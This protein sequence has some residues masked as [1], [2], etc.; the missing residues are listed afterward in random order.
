MRRVRIRHA[1]APR[2]TDRSRPSSARRSFASLSF[3]F[4]RQ[5][6]LGDGPVPFD[7]GGG[8]VHGRGRFLDGGAAE[9]PELDEARLFGIEVRELGQC[10]VEIEQV[11]RWLAAGDESLVE[12][13]TVARAAALGG[14]ARAGALDQNLTH[15][16]RGDGAEVGA[17]LPPA[18]AVLHQ[19]QVGLV[20][21]RRRLQR[22]PRFLAADVTRREPAQLLVDEWQKNVDVPLVGHTRLIVI[23]LIVTGFTGRS[24]RPVGTEPIRFTTSI[25]STT[26]PK[27]ECRLSRCGVG[28]RVMKNWLPLVL[29]PALAIDRMPARLWRSDGWN[30]SS[31]L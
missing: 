26:S 31:N 6:G 25:P 27:T 16:V 20:H 21:E 4:A 9:E 13:D 12:G 22:L 8:D 19:P 28:P 5:P 17:V 23:W 18:R 11:D 1:R 14:A 30:S 15:R 7:G 3:E 10:R 2:E 29:G 24:L